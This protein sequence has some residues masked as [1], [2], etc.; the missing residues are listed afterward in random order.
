MRAGCFGI[1]CL[2]QLS[3]RTNI[4]RYG[5]IQRDEGV[6]LEV[7]SPRSSSSPRVTARINAINSKTH[8]QFARGGTHKVRVATLSSAILVFWGLVSAALAQQATPTTNV[9][10]RTL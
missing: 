1:A 9:L 7:E 5:G 2:R 10:T 6:P 3:R 4:F 8:V